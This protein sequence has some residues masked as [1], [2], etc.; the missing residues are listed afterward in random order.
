MVTP[1]SDDDAVLNQRAD[2]HAGADVEVDGAA[3]RGSEEAASA[4]WASVVRAPDADRSPDAKQSASDERS[5]GSDDSSY[6]SDG[7]KG[8]EPSGAKRVSRGAALRASIAAP[9]VASNDEKA[10]ERSPKSERLPKAEQLPEAEQAPKNERTERDRP[11]RSA[12]IRDVLTTTGGGTNKGE[13]A[14]GGASAPQ[15]RLQPALDATPTA[16]PSV[17]ANANTD[18]RKG[19]DAMN[20]PEPRRRSLNL[21][22][23]MVELA[24]E[25]P[26]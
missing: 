14:S 6:G 11:R 5:L 15:G 19:T 21:P 22:P 7:E 8:L 12:A 4:R 16:E 3:N 18:T 23:W 2:A 1:R 10:G 13:R 26:S 17:L 9:S 24:D 25:K 20:A